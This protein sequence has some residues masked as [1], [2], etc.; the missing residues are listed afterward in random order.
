MARLSP[1]KRKN[2]KNE[3]QNSDIPEKRNALKLITDHAELISVEMP[4]TLKV[5]HLH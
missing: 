2:K 4:D 3:D 5:I 1:A